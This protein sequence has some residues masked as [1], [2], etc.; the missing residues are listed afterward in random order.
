[1]WAKKKKMGNNK[2]KIGNGF[3]RVGALNGA[4]IK[5]GACANSAPVNLCRRNFLSGG[6][7]R[8]RSSISCYMI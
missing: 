4:T 2:D 6:S 1:L 7:N 8:A 3:D 5:D